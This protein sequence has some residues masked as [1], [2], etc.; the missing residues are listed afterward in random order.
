MLFGPPASTDGPV[1]D[2]TQRCG[3]LGWVETHFWAPGR[4]LS[5]YST[6]DV[7]WN[8]IRLKE[9][10]ADNQPPSAASQQ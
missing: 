2:D 7:L 5:Q 6:Q 10:A 1:Q 4:Q 3:I 8:E 9:G